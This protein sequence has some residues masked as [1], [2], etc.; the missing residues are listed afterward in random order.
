[1]PT[2]FLSDEDTELFKEFQKH[3]K[4]FKAL[5]EG[6]FF[7]FKSGKAE[8]HKSAEGDIQEIYISSKTYKKTK[9]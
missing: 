8:I 4:E 2:I 3:Y 1:M 7:E 9:I 6:K 5:L